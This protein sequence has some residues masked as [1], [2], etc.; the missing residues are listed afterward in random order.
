MCSFVSCGGGDDEEQKV[1]QGRIH[2]EISYPYN[3]GK[4]LLASMLP[5]HMVMTFKG[6]HLRIAVEEK[7]LSNVI[8]TDESDKSL[9][10]LFR[11]S[12]KK[13]ACQLNEEQIHTFLSQFPDVEYIET[14]Q[15]MVIAGYDTK[16][17]TAVFM[18]ASRE[19][20]LFYTDDIKIPNPNWPT[21]YKEVPGVLLKYDIQK[22]GLTMRFTAT[23]VELTDIPDSDF[24]AP[25]EFKRTPFKELEQEIVTMFS[26]VQ[27]NM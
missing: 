24:E 26:Q 8:I 1:V 25:S 12:S 22:Y 6:P 3:D 14:G 16:K 15:T 5:T 10:M 19:S 23:K 2:Y 17:L 4:S 13:M 7:I 11:F 20:E 9:M 27:D 21:P 18:N